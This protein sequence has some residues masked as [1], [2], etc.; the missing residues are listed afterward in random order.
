[1]SYSFFFRFFTLF[2]RCCQWWESTLFFHSFLVFFLYLFL[3]FF[4]FVFSESTGP[5]DLNNSGLFFREIATKQ[6]GNFLSA[7]LIDSLVFLL[8]HDSE[9]LENLLT[10]I[11]QKLRFSARPFNF[12][13]SILGYVFTLRGDT[14][15]SARNFTSFHEVANKEIGKFLVSSSQRITHLLARP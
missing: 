9:L 5:L 8:D 13:T 7:R 1:M 12:S 4:L 10:Y 2:F 6:T 15:E 11:S 3:S 14:E